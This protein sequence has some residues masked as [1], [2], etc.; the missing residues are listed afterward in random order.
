MASYR[1]DTERRFSR[2]GVSLR[3]CTRADLPTILAI[4]HASYPSPWTYAAFVRELH[5]QHGR[6]FVAEK[7]GERLAGVRRIILGYI[8]SWLIVDE[9]HILNIAVHPNARQ[10]GIARAL[11]DKTLT[12][13]QHA[14]ACTANLEVRQSNTAAI[15]LYQQFGFQTVATRRK[16][17]HNGEDALLMVCSLE[18]LPALSPAAATHLSDLC[19]NPAKNH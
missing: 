2:S 4:E 15:A 6:F 19:P 12:E 10:Q 5:N 17:Y 13:G 1:R 7:G 18:P 16:Y 3:R 11:L 8:C 14:G 9:V